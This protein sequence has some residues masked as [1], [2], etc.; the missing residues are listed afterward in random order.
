AIQ[1]VHRMVEDSKEDDGSISSCILNNFANIIRNVLNRDAAID[2]TVLATGTI[3]YSPSFR[4]VIGES[5][6][7]GKGNT[8]AKLMCIAFDMAIVRAHCKN[9]FP[10]WLIH[11]GVFEYMDE[12]KRKALLGEMIEYSQLGIQHIVTMIDSD[13]PSGEDIATFLG[14][15][16]KIVLTLSDADDQGLLFKG[17]R[18]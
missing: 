8:Y 10:R 12:R 5:T 11:D 6:D 17:V 1:N 4:D 2:I 3:D 16:C 9:R 13:V 18:W 7:E 15:Q 14:K